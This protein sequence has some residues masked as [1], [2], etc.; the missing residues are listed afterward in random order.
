MGRARE[1]FGKRENR[2][3]QEKIKTDLKLNQLKEW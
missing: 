3:K 2:T 1:T